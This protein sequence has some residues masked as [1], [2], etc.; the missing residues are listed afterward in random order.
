MIVALE[1]A[2]AA[3]EEAVETGLAAVGVASVGG[4][5]RWDAEVSHVRCSSPGASALLA[6]HVRV[7]VCS[8]T[9]ERWWSGQG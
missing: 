4:S 5:A 9:S 7:L 3:E 1:V 6:T 2:V 8:F